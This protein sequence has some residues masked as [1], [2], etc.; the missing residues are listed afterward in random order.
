M[1][2]LPEVE[3]VVRGLRATIVGRTFARVHT[4]APTASIVVSPSLPKGGLEKNLPDRAVLGV[5]R[6]GKNILIRL[7]GDLTLWVH[8]KMTGRFLYV[9]ISQPLDKHDLAVFDFRPDEHT[10]SLHL[11]F[12][13]YRRFGRL[14]LFPN[15]E[16]MW[17]PGLVD[18]GPEPLEIAVDDFVA[19]CRKRDRMIKAALLDQRFLAGLGNI[20]ADEALH[21]SRI[22]PKRLTQS[23]S[24]RKLIDLHAHIQRL[25]KHAIRL[26]GTSVRTYSAVNGSPGAFQKKLLVYGHE[27]H[28]CGRCGTKIVREMIGSRS[29]HYCPRCQKPGR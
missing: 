27:G 3:T 21:A 13:D 14:R 18:L 7:S 15:H 26:M 10:G 24:R 29:A 6:R 17:Q 20:Y 4:S 8:L 1:P 12:N 19:L 5:D 22:H 23:L 28:P 16:L 11:R 2:E 9:D 25:L